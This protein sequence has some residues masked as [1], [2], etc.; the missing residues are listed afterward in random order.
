MKKIYFLLLSILTFSALN[1]Q[2]S[3]FQPGPKINGS[4]TSIL[5]D[6]DDTYYIGGSFTV[7]G[8]DTVSGIMRWDGNK[9]TKVGSTGITGASIQCMVKYN[10]NVVVAGNF[11]SIDSVSCNNIA[12]WDGTNWNP[13]GNG[14]EYTGATTVSTL[15]VFKGD[16][17]AAGSF[18][19]SGSDSVS[20]I[21]KWDGTDWVP[22]QDGV[23]GVVRTMCE[24]NGELYVGGTFPYAGGLAVN[25]IA[26]WDGND[27]YPVGD[28]L[29]Y[30]GATTVSTLQVYNGNLYAGGI[31]HNSGTVSIE[32]VARWDGSNWSDVAGGLDY[33]GATTVSTLC[34]TVYNEKLIAEAKYRSTTDT[35]VFYYVAQTWND[36]AWTVKQSRTDLPILTLQE[37]GS[38]LFAGGDFTIIDEDTISFF[39][40]WKWG[41]FRKGIVYEEEKHFN[42]SVYP[43]PSHG[44]LW[45]RPDNNTT[46]NFELNDMLGRVVFSSGNV[47]DTYF[48]DPTSLKAGM[49]SYRIT[50]DKGNRLQQGKLIIE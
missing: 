36:T 39:A 44:E 29:E 37:V 8:N 30:T 10:G 34:F 22:L 28:G 3:W 2:H 9:F 40:E 6:V 31:F 12:Y 38:D 20:N 33:T 11:N 5:P 48:I 21:A 49:Y 32:H 26:K 23:K 25:N 1:A 14:L 46:F 41:T 45:I 17:Y 19:V 15:T 18:Q 16:L 50:D 4:V 7:V 35:T 47:N 13:F 24:Y 43:N 42:F 27:W